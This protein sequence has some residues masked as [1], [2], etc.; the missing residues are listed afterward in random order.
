[1]PVMPLV[2]SKSLVKDNAEM[3]ARVVY[4]LLFLAAVC[5]LAVI[6]GFIVIAGLIADK[7][8]RHHMKATVTGDTSRRYKFWIIK[9]ISLIEKYKE[10]FEVLMGQEDCGIVQGCVQDVKV[11]FLSFIS[12]TVNQRR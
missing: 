3:F 10:S 6:S 4:I 9:V 8:K 12:G 5:S 11:L 1:M 7:R 2:C